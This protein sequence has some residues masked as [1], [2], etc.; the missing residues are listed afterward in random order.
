MPPSLA[1]RAPAPTHAVALRGPADFAGWRRA[2]RRLLAAEVPPAAVGWR[3]D[4]GAQPGLLDAATE[5]EDGGA[6][7]SPCRVPRHLIGVA[8]Q[9]ALH[10]DPG[11][12]DLL[13]RLLWRVAH[14]E[15]GILLRSG[16]RDVARAE[17][18]AAAVR[19]AARELRDLARFREVAA[20]AGPRHV[21]WF[22]PEH[23]VVERAA[24]W[25][26][27]RF[28]GR[29]WSLVTPMG[30]A[31]G[32]GDGKIRFAAGAHR[33]ELPP[34]GA[35]EAAWATFA[36][37]RSAPAGGPGAEVVS[38]R[39]SPPD[40]APA[41]PATL[42]LVTAA[43]AAEQPEAV[44]RL[45]D[46][47][48]ADAGLRPGGDLARAHARAFGQR[49]CDGALRLARERARLRPGLVVALGATAAEALLGRSVFL[50]LE[51]GRFLP[52]DD[53]GRLL[54]TADPASVL[55][56]ADATA[57]GR[58][59]RRLVSDLLLAVPYRRRAA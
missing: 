3:V 47:A 43:P 1:A 28:A 9:A 31:H 20:A 16:D 15:R 33:R 55:G 6:A 21:A 37:R 29:R 19:R 49:R 25:F 48:L 5:H 36:L 8:E 11:R 38:L 13:Y 35:G 10:A 18:M 53:G 30:S 12:F 45:L 54:A 32:E 40:A 59:Y 58:E 27:G 46:R 4:G 41:F 23:H 52:L 57:Q 34:P 42:L 44:R 39:R 50:P 22:E 2:A 7:A 26:A 14:G 24:P 17:A 56:L 51:R